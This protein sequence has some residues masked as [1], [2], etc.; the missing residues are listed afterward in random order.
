GEGEAHAAPRFE[1]ADVKLMS[2]LKGLDEHHQRLA[3][4]FLRM[5]IR[6]GR[7]TT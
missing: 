7:A 2:D 6:L 1:S 5:L 4:E 3:R